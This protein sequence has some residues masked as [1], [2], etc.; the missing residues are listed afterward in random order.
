VVVFALGVLV[1]SEAEP[2]GL[3]SAALA[4]LVGTA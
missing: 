3:C 2:V 1:V 4:L